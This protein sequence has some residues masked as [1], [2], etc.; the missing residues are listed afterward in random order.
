[1]IQNALLTAPSSPLTASDMVGRQSVIVY[2]LSAL[3]RTDSTIDYSVAETPGA[4]NILGGPCP[5]CRSRPKG[6]CHAIRPMRALLI[7]WG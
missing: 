6:G 5:S 4:S 1:M 3:T 7:P 2:Q